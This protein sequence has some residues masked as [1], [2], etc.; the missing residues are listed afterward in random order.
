MVAAKID[1]A[2]NI[3][4]GE[5]A[6]ATAGPSPSCRSIANIDLGDDCSIASRPTL[7]TKRA[8][9][10]SV[11]ERCSVA[12]A[13]VGL[14][15]RELCA[16]IRKNEEGARHRVGRVEHDRELPSPPVSPASATASTRSAMRNRKV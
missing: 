14:G 3:R 11:G 10:D 6:H 7:S 1:E 5:F 15:D 8:S 4:E 13:S 16:A 2:A 12:K 9:R